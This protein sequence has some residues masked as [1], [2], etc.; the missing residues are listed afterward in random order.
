MVELNTP[1]KYYDHA[2]LIIIKSNYFT[3]NIY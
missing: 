1:L 2:N 3:I